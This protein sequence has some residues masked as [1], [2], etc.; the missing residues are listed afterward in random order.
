MFMSYKLRT[1]AVYFIGFISTIIH[2]ITSQDGVQA[3]AVNTAIT[4][5][6]I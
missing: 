1:R 4:L 5:R 6:A 3:Q 2:T